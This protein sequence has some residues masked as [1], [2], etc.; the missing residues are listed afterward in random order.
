[1]S[2]Y[3]KEILKLAT[4]IM[5][6]RSHPFSVE[7]MEAAVL[8]CIVNIFV[9]RSKL[10]DQIEQLKESSTPL[11]YVYSENDKIMSRKLNH[12]L[13]KSLG[14][15]PE[16]VA[17]YHREG[18]LQREGSKTGPVEVLKFVSGGH[19]SYKKHSDAV[20]EAVVRFLQKLDC[21]D[22]FKEYNA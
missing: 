16:F 2:G 14:V 7:D 4:Q 21:Q 12:N 1:M 20:N 22:S 3:E 10:K 8:G 13:M 17:H 11:L 18:Q 6:L 15:K 19:F 9:N 5:K